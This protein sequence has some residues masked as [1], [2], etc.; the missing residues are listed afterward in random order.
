LTAGSVFTPAHREHG[1]SILSDP[2]AF[3]SPLAGRVIKI[4][5]GQSQAVSKNQ[6]LVVIE[7]MKMENELCAPYDAVIKTQYIFEGDV[8]KT[9]QVLLSLERKK[10]EGDA[11][12]EDG[13]Q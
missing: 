13:N 10:G 2:G 3:T 7:S 9:N 6:P 4:L 1:A 12:T 11:T 8:V 5:V